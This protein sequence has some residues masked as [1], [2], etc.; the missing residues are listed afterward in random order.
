MTERQ[1]AE[2]VLWGSRKKKKVDQRPVK[3]A[4]RNIQSQSW[5]WATPQG[6]GLDSGQLHKV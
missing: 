3:N 2:I 4:D 1:P 6:L 5:L